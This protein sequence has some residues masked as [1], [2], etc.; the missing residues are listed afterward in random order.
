MYLHRIPGLAE[1]FVY[2][3]DDMMPMNG[4]AISSF[5]AEAG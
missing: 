3:N 5:F 4:M 1:H 2:S